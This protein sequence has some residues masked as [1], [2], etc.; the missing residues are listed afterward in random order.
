MPHF[1]YLLDSLC[2]I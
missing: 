1:G 2:K